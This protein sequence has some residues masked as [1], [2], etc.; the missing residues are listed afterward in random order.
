MVVAYVEIVA[1]VQDV[2]V[3][4]IGLRL[5]LQPSQFW[6][7]STAVLYIL[8]VPSTVTLFYITSARLEEDCGVHVS[9]RLRVHGS[10]T[11]FFSCHT[12]SLGH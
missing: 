2:A 4:F 11:D 12:S 6:N 3:A 5:Q 7:Y 8:A 10:R 9:P 1:V